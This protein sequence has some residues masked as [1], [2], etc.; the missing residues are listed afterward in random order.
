MQPTIRAAHTKCFRYIAKRDLAAAR[1]Q[2]VHRF[3]T[4]SIAR[5]EAGTKP[6]QSKDAD[7]KEDQRQEPGAMSRRLAQMSE[8][9]L[10]DSGR[11]AAKVVQEAGFDE[12]LKR[13]LEERIKAA[14]FRSEHASAFAQAELPS[15]AGQGT[16]DIAG[17]RAWT[18]EESIEDASLR[19]LNDSIKPMRGPA[20]PPR[21]PSVRTPTRVDTGHSRTKPNSGSRLANARDKTSVY[22]AMKDMPETEREAFRK[23]MK[24]RFSPAAR[25]VPVSI[26]GLESLA[27][28]RIEDAIARGKFKNLPR[29]Q[30]I[31][32]DY[33]ASSPFINTTEYLLNR[34]IQRQDIVPPWIEKQQE[35]VST[36]TRFRGR[37]RADWKRH[38]A[39][40][41]ASKGGSLESQLA[42]AD[43]YAFAETVHNPQP[44]KSE[45]LN[46]VD[47]AGH[48][49]QITLAGELKPG[50]DSQELKITQETIA[51]TGDVV[52][53]QPEQR[54]N[55]EVAAST[56]PAVEETKRMPTVPPFRDQQWLQTETSF[57]KLAIENLNS[58]TR[59][60]N[61]MCPQLAQRPYFDLQRELK[62]CFADVA[63][64][65]AKEIRGM[66]TH[67][68]SISKGVS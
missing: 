39:R 7:E 48:I 28:E 54:V 15:S 22:A 8:E 6:S 67:W 50:Q 11:R 43:E 14:S 40:T 42:L 5:D 56:V 16:R 61:L 59:S 20:R 65:V 49:S 66:S 57:Q 2:E 29:G 52:Q 60:Y 30:K 13:Q 1:S 31:E 24:E 35:L 17:A 4:S 33:N 12:D 18:G 9:S 38:V 27:N 44:K 62:A 45:K 47:E 64:H 19:M 58:L 23:E 37:L 3:S 63:P 41:I 32:R 46:T 36:A 21:T 34:M 26:R 68:S 25:S 53:S 10:E 55:I 51:E